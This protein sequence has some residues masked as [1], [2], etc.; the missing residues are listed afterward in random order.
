SFS[1]SIRMRVLFFCRVLQGQI[2]KHHRA[3]TRYRGS[4][5]L[6]QREGC[7]CAK[8]P[9]HRSSEVYIIK[10]YLTRSILTTFAHQRSH[11]FTERVIM[12][13]QSP[14]NPYLVI[15]RAILAHLK[16]AFQAC[17]RHFEANDSSY[18]VLHIV[19]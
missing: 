12:P 5:M 8:L 7:T 6:W 9:G 18:F 19:I 15:N 1:S 13:F 11:I 2:R 16:L 10:A 17:N 4:K 14:Y 3:A